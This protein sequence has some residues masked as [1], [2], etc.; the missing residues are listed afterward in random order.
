MV[1]LVLTTVLL[2]VRAEMEATAQRMEEKY[3]LP[4]FAHGVVVK[5]V[6][7]PRNIPAGNVP[8]NYWNRKNCYAIAC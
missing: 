7:V 1:L 2:C 4:R 3:E 8:Q 5:F 6:G